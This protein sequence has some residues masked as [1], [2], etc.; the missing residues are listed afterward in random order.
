MTSKRSGGSTEPTLCLR[1]C[2]CVVDARSLVKIETRKMCVE[3]RSVRGDSKVKVVRSTVNGAEGIGT[4]LNF[5]ELRFMN[6]WVGCLIIH[7]S[8]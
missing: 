3:T 2:K 8:T 5:D 4:R 1:P 7:E 6:D